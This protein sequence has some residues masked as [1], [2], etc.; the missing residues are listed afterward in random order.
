MQFHVDGYRAGDPFVAEAHPSV[1]H[2]TPGVP[3]R[4]DVL[5]V[6]AGPAGLVVAAVLAK[7]PEISTTVVDRRNGPL[8]IGQAD[9]VACRTMEMLQAFGLARRLAEESYQVNEV[10]FWR[11][12]RRRAAS[13][14]PGAP[15]TSRTTCPRCRTSSSTR[16]GCSTTCVTT[17]DGRRAGPSRSTGWL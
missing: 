4:T 8:Q 1:P 16:P 14:A 5:I 11:P 9:G 6:G 10:A 15:P 7:I 12:G 2:R 3:A 17:C 13:C